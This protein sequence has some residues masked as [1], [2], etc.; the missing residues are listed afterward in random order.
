[1]IA[2]AQNTPPSYTPMC[3]QTLSTTGLEK[4]YLEVATVVENISLDRPPCTLV[5]DGWKNSANSPVMVYLQ[6]WQDISLFRKVYDTTGERRTGL[7]ICSQAEDA[8]KIIGLERICQF[9]TDS[10]GDCKAGRRIFCDKYPWI[11]NGNCSCHCLDLLM[12][13]IV[14]KIDWAEGNYTYWCTLIYSY[15]VLSYE[16]A[17]NTQPS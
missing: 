2:A 10:G 5:A 4:K 8:G 15:H 7:V 6:A 13:D 14:E 9:V 11:V 1:M 3:R 12:E 16:F 17:K